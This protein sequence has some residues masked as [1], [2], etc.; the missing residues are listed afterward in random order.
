MDNEE[1]LGNPLDSLNPMDVNYDQMNLT[2]ALNM[3]AELMPPPAPV[4]FDAAPIPMA[5]VPVAPA[6]VMTPEELAA[7]ERNLLAQLTP[8]TAP[9]APAAAPAIAPQA[10]TSTTTEQK[11]MPAGTK[12]AVK[13]FDE[14]GLIG[15]GEHERF[16]VYNEKFQAKADAK[17]EK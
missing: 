15:E 6:P 3:D 1:I 9:I 12:A 5:P 7:T 14:A 17:L 8:A 10:S 4:T 11:I 13:A 16:I 2:G